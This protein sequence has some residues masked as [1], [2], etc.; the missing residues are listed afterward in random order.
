LANLARTQKDR[1]AVRSRGSRGGATARGSG[2]LVEYL[3]FR[4]AG[5]LYAVPVTAV[6]EIVKPPTITPVPR[7]PRHVL[8]IM[9]GRG[10]VVTVVD[11]RRKLRLE[12]LPPSPKSRVLIA[13]TGEERIGLWVDE[14]LMVFRFGE[15]E[16]ERSALAVGGDVA[17]HIAGIARPADTKT[18]ARG[19]EQVGS[20]DVLILLDLKALL[21]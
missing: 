1:G 18:D 14:V 15:S 11:T 5:E 10:R 7:A 17:P 19:R 20:S 6:Q 16:I 12:E 4:L 13:D 3:A 8:G 21:T 9:S 2:T